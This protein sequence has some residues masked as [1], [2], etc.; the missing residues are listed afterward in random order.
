MTLDVVTLGETMVLM[1][2][3]QMGPL[4]EATTFHRDVAGAE[5][6][7]AIGL[8]RLGCTAGWISRL[9]DDEFGQAILFRLRGEGVDTSRVTIDH[10]RPTGILFRERREHGPIA[11][12]YYR[13]GSAASA[14]SPEDL[15]VDYVR[16]ARYLFLTGITPALSPSCR[17]ASFAAIE[18]AR[19]AHVP[20]VLDPNYRSKLWPAD[21]A[22]AV[23]R[24]LVGHCDI[25]LSGQAEA[26]LLTG[27]ADAEVAA[28]SLARLGPAMVVVKLG[29]HG[30]LALGERIV[31]RIGPP[32]ARVIDPVGAGDAFAAGFLAGVL[33]GRPIEAALDLANACGASV[34]A[35]P[36]DVAGLPTL[37]EIDGGGPDADV[38]R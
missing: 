29:E 33:L 6:T 2:A 3:K 4:R 21:E 8:C 32:V 24:D 14:L 23:L 12:V 31:R 27:D 30:A 19:A 35:T 7:V 26:E 28:R 1:L 34:A 16:S 11:V 18:I 25:V 17:A 20:V 38:L 13:R 10:T 15:D 22:R 37:R 36:G 5:S 9:G